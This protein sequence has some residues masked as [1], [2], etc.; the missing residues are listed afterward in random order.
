[1]QA[2]V[3]ISKGP[4]LTE[5]REIPA[6][7]PGRGEVL[8][9]VKA[10]A[11][12]ASDVHLFQDRFTYEPPLVLGHE[13][14]GVVELL[15]PEV[16]EISVGDRVVSENNPRA[17][18][19]CKVCREGYPNLCPCKRAMG[20]KADGCFADYI[21]LPAALLHRVPEGVS[22]FAAALSEPLA[23]AVHAVE[24]RGGICQGDTVVVLGPGAIGLLAA[25]IAR[26]EGAARVVVAGTGKDEQLRMP[27][28]RDLGFKTVNV[29]AEDLTKMISSLTEGQGADVVVEASGSGAAIDTAIALLRRAGRMIVAGI[30]GRDTVP[31]AWDAL[32]AK[33][34]TI[35]FSYSSRKRNWT[36]AMQYLADGSVLTEPLITHRLPLNS[37]REAFDLMERQE[38][39]RTVL[40]MQ[41]ST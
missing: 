33:G 8:I 29:E 3:K 17:C 12:C 14:S 36:K 9:R 31:L 19:E 16:D 7:E 22:F 11:V 35:F 1:L 27:R 18:G 21:T 32:V 2:L 13:F 5:I 25:Q 30:T 34:A 4:G 6:P 15:G 28:A 38:C 41:P 10:A 20:F 39:I 26:A 37:W 40:E 23:V 24:D